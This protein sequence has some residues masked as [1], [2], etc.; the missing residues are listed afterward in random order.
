MKEDEKMVR[1]IGVLTKIDIMDKGTNCR[2][3]LL[4][5][6]VA[7]RLG[8]VAIVNR[9]KQDILDNIGVAKGVEREA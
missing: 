6:T 4:N 3:E 8:Y 2:K 9:S 7:L 1:T 5:E